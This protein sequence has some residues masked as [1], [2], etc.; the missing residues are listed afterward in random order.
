MHKIRCVDIHTLAYTLFIWLGFFFIFLFLVEIL[1]KSQVCT[2][3]EECIHILLMTYA[4]L[5]LTRFIAF[6]VSFI[7]IVMFYYLSLSVFIYI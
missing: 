2:P 1:L 4:N 3:V 7:F 6:S 5:G